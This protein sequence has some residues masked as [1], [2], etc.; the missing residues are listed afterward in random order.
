[1]LAAA[2]VYDLDVLLLYQPVL[3]SRPPD[4]FVCFGSKTVQSLHC[5]A[6]AELSHDEHR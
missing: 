1:M 3:G 6:A 2:G 5:K 4:R